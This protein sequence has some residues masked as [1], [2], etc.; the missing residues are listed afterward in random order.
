MF[1][2]S[3]NAK[4]QPGTVVDLDYGGG[5]APDRGLIG[6]S[7]DGQPLV[8][9]GQSTFP[10]GLPLH[11]DAEEAECTVDPCWVRSSLRLTIGSESTVLATG[12]NGE[13]GGLT[14]VNGYYE[15]VQPCGAVDVYDM[16]LL[17]GYSTP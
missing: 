17:A 4:L 9:V 7:R 13:V 10:V 16:F 5:R 1:A 6:V 12:E 3:S 2:L 11:L 15:P 8:F 14:L